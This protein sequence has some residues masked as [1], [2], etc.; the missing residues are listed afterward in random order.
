M[1]SEN[2]KRIN[3]E[4][5]AVWKNAKAVPDLPGDMSRPARRRRLAIERKADKRL[6]KNR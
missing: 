3:L 6:K 4:R 2:T 5:G 1:A